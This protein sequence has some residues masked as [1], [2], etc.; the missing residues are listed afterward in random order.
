MSTNSCKRRG[1]IIEV[2][3]PKGNFVTFIR[4]VTR[5][6]LRLKVLT[7]RFSFEIVPYE[8]LPELTVSER[9]SLSCLSVKFTLIVCVL[10]AAI[11]LFSFK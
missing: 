6:S 4:G 7:G 8:L 9:E 11:S 5:Y 3:L 10:I 1:N 2:Y